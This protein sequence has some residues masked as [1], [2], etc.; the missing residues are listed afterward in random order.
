M[1]IDDIRTGFRVETRVLKSKRCV[2]VPSVRAS[3]A[4]N[5]QEVKPARRK[6]NDGARANKCP[7]LKR[8][9]S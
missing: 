1:V 3:L 7:G 6:A 9:E 8:L 2:F 4:S 5:L